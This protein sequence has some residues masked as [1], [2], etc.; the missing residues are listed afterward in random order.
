MHGAKLYDHS[1]D[2][3][4]LTP[5]LQSKL[6]ATVDEQ[7]RKDNTVVNHIDDATDI[8]GEMNAKRK[9]SKQFDVDLGGCRYDRSHLFTENIFSSIFKVEEETTADEHID[10]TH[11]NTIRTENL[12]TNVLPI[13]LNDIES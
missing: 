5:E 11:D 6:N 8:L 4:V 12:F 9:I 1:P 3:V 13:F 7:T 10:V 2:P